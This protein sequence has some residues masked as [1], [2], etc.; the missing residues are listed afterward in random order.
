MRLS[1]RLLGVAAVPAAI[2]ALAG[3]GS[4]AP[5]RAEFV[6]KADTICAQ[7]NKAHPPVRPAKGL[8]AGGQ[9][10][11]QEV[12]IRKE[13]DAKLRKLDVPAK[14]KK[15]FAAYNAG[16]GR[17]IAEIGQAA[18]DAAAGNRP[19]YNA[20][21]DQVRQIGIARERIAVRIG[22]R[23]CGRATPAPSPGP[24]PSG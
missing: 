9:Q 13:L 24:R 3:C 5:T 10:A 17:I 2:A 19:K 4:S 23:T 8:K 11:A 21:L 18:K 16:T 12:Q 22:F 20:D 6:K 7:V 14:L 1:S 15:D